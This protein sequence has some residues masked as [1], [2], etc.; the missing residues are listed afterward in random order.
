[1]AN[2]VE[3][4]KEDYCSRHDCFVC[5]SADKPTFGNCWRE[6]VSYS[7][8]CRRCLKKGIQATYFGESGYSG[9][10]RSKFHI[11]ALKKK[12][13]KSVLYKHNIE[14]HPDLHLTE[15]D[16]KMVILGGSGRPVVRQC[17]E[18]ILIQRALEAAEQGQRLQ[19]L[20]SKSEFLQPGTVGRSFSGILS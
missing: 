8:S 13:K 3:P 10:F 1:M 7:I 4:H 12:S 20:N 2:F 16:F 14:Q 15:D 9:Y 17:Q 5:K 18:G 6:G 11:D 19:L